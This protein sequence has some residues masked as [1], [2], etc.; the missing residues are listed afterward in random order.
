MVWLQKYSR[1]YDINPIETGIGL[2]LNISEDD[3]SLDLDL[4]L[5]VHKYFRLSDNRVKEIIY[6]VKK[7][8]KSWRNVATKYNIPRNEQELTT[9][10]FSKIEK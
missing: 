9:K 10:A 8:V 3:N 5:E 7:A 2:S 1:V 4:A 6:E